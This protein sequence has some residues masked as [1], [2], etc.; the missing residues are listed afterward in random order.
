MPTL[1]LA[2]ARTFTAAPAV[3]EPPP[4]PVGALDTFA[5]FLAAFNAA[6]PDAG[7]ARFYL[8]ASAQEH[9]E[10]AS[11]RDAIGNVLAVSVGAGMSYD[12]ERGGLVSADG[13]S[14]TLKFA[15]VG[16]VGTDGWG[17][18][19][20]HSCDVAAGLAYDCR[21]IAEPAS[22]SYFRAMF[23]AASRDGAAGADKIAIA[24]GGS[25]LTF[26]G[27]V[28][29][30]TPNPTKGYAGYPELV[31]DASGAP[32]RT[33]INAV[34]T[35]DQSRRFARC[36]ATRPVGSVIDGVYIDDGDRELLLATQGVVLG[37][38]GCFR[39]VLTAKQMGVCDLY[40]VDAFG[41]TPSAAAGKYNLIAPG[42]SIFEAPWVFDDLF[43]GG[44]AID[45]DGPVARAASYA[46]ANGTHEWVPHNLGKSGFPWKYSDWATL[47][48]AASLFELWWW[49]VRGRYDA[50]AEAN[51]IL[52]YEDVN[53]IRVQF[54]AGR[55]DPVGDCIAHSDEVLQL[56][57]DAFP[58]D[59][60]IVLIGCGQRGASDAFVADIDARRKAAFA[61]GTTPYT[62][63]ID[64]WATNPAMDT[65]DKFVANGTNLHLDRSGSVFGGEL[66]GARFVEFFG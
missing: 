45:V 63:Y 62:R 20:I 30:H 56:Y 48:T 3:E 43:D 52:A 51:V 25:P 16:A 34:E 65:D 27:N 37:F 32:M 55:P 39:G 47:D 50:E 64:D 15:N 29:V 9:R 8:A 2:H 6:G 40:G 10:G 31:R 11:L 1:R 7:D 61:L 12:A 42:N 14:G 13:G 28:N 19:S 21:P 35:A 5:K 4:P 18:V 41:Q 58:A 54:N 57:A 44:G 49:D 23:N 26:G 17:I 24:S 59:T 38:I 60:E 33:L 46:T 53:T 66:V 36:G 22:A